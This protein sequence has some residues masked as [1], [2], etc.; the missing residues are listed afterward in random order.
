[1][2]TD[3][4]GEAAGLVAGSASAVGLT[5]V[6]SVADESVHVGSNFVVGANRRDWHLLN[7][8]T[9]RDFTPDLVGDIA[10]AEA[11][12]R[13]VHCGGEFIAERG[14]EVGHV[15]KL[16]TFF[17]E[18]LNATFLS[19]EGSLQPAIMGCYGI[20]IGRLLAAAIEHNRDER[21]MMLPPSVAPFQVY[22]AA[23]N[24]EDAAVAEAA[25]GV[26]R[27]LAAAGFE[28]LYDDRAESA[29]VKF[30]DADLLGFP[31]RVVVSPRNLREEKSP[32]SSAVTPVPPGSCRWETPLRPCPPCSPS[33]PLCW[34][35]SL[36]AHACLPPPP[37]P[38][39]TPLKGPEWTTRKPGPDPPLAGAGCCAARCGPLPIRAMPL[40]GRSPCFPLCHSSW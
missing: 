22:L 21:G 14:V 39:P 25:D 2:P 37:L 24:A 15:F 5:G 11:G 6:R 38:P 40:S 7:V 30:N 19:P 3:E 36:P 28:T 23:L 16:G 27:A 18:A 17:S 35:S 26:Y 10:L 34:R 31:V 32:R 9:P 13:C 20:G 8:N 29:G 1:M 12:H 4:E 33:K